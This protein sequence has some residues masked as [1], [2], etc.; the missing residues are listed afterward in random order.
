MHNSNPIL[1][2]FIGK[3]HMHSVGLEPTTSPSIL[4]QQE[5]EVPFELELIG[6][7]HIL[8]ILFIRLVYILIVLEDMFY[9]IEYI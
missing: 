7:D 9:F 6:S 2:F 1:F 4:L 8:I 3:L 5:K